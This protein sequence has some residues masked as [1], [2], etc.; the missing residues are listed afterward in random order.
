MNR[1]EK[2]ALDAIVIGSDP[3]A[4]VAATYLAKAGRSVLL[5]DSAAAL[6][7]AM[8]TDE[9]APGCRASATFADA[10]HFAPEI[11]HDLKLARHGL[12]FASAGSL[13]VPQLEG[14][15]LLLEPP[16]RRWRKR[17]LTEKSPLDRR[18][19]E[20]FPA[21]D[22]F[23]RK[24]ADAFHAVFTQPLPDLGNSGMGNTLDLLRRGWRLRRLGAHDLAEAMRTLPMS[25]ADVLEEHFRTDALAA[26]IAMDGTKGSWLGP[27]SPGS[28]LNLLLHRIGRHR[29]A[30][31]YPEPVLG[32]TGALVDALTSAARA[33]GVQTRLGTAID[34]VLV[35]GG[36]AQ[37]IVLENGEEV[38][39]KAVL[40]SRDPRS[41]L[42]GLVD[43]FDLEPEFLNAVRN[44]RGRG[45]A[46]I[47]KCVLGRLP[48]FRGAPN[49]PRYL[50]GRIQIGDTL[51]SL[52]QAFDA[53]KYGRIPE[54]P[55]LEIHLPSITD[56]DL[57]P[58]DK[59]VLH[60]WVQHTPYRLAEGDWD[61]EKAS[62]A[63]LVERRIAEYD[64]AFPTY[65]ES[66]DVLTP[67]DIERRFGLREGCL[68]H[69]EPALDQ[70]L[71]MRPIPGWGQYRTPIAGLYLC[72]AGC[73]SGGPLTGL[74]GRNAARQ[75]LKTGG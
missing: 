75:V 41:T 53:N 47:V 16:G 14:R 31:S 27:R 58:K 66:V 9:F 20:A 8:V 18:D 37:G 50:A 60:A 1:P 69:V 22:A 26:L 11:V 36:Q 33:V 13:F 48:Q 15:P 10:S 21:F 23:L 72:G 34:R 30:L 65:V 51:D 42:L 55:T 28:T 25:L 45:T 40:S 35:R 5:A 74:P 17:L 43:P 64:P 3:N 7:G 6:G 56:P 49:D 19:F 70:L 63:R 44:I 73:H 12:K 46:A 4:L 62:L 67:L 68:Y 39:A 38:R 24:L 71:Y 54:R 57:A 59:V 29:G 32:G 52:E 2:N 61:G